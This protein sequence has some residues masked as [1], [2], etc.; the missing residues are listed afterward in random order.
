MSAAYYLARLGYCVTVFEA[1]PV[2]A[3]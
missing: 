3:A 2:P 1:M